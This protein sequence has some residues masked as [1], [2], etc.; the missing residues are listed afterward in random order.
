MTDR[1]RVVRAIDLLEHL[2]REAP[3]EIPAQLPGI[4]QEYHRNEQPE[5][6]KVSRWSPGFSRKAA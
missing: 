5:L 4:V 3:E 2:A 1:V 6:V